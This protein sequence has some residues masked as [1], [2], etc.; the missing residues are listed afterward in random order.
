M[1]VFFVPAA[2]VIAMHRHLLTQEKKNSSQ[3]RHLFFLLDHPQK[4]TAAI[5]FLHLY[6]WNSIQS[7]FFLLTAAAAVTRAFP[8]CGINK[9]FVISSYRPGCCAGEG[10]ASAY[11]SSTTFPDDTLT[12]IKS[13]PLMD[14]SVPSVNDRPYFTRT[15]SRYGVYLF[16]ELDRWWNYWDAFSFNSTAEILTD[17][18]FEVLRR[19]QTISSLC[20]LVLNLSSVK[21]YL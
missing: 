4:Q 18:S 19:N 8:Q 6:P 7:F 16:N 21:P 13:Y 2:G 15:T 11:K 20:V 12:F 14:E 3:T 10:S 1:R 17:G 5:V 9:V